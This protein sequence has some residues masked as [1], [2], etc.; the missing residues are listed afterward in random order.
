MAF[1]SCDCPIVGPISDLTT[2]NCGENFGQIQRIIL[3]R[4]GY[5]F[6]GTAGKDIT[7]LADWQ[8]VI[9][10]GDDTKA[11]ITPFLVNA[12]IAGGEKITIGGGDNSTL[13]GEA[14]LVGINPSE[15]T[16]I[17]RSLTSAQITELQSFNCEKSLVVYFVNEFGKI[18]AKDLTGGSYTGFP[19]SSFFSGEKNVNGF[20]TL[21]ETPVDF[22]LKKGWSC[23]YAIVTPADFD[24]LSDI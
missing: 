5:T 7:L 19:I 16:S 14:E 18:I 4:K 1:V 8:T 23:D 6:D 15:F 9:A 2:L 13:N 12:I 11:A 10:A 20:G 3:Q 17:A 24:P 21:D 22:T